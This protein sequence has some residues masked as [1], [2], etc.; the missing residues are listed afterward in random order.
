MIS[1]A[2]IRLV[3]KQFDAIHAIY[4]YQYQ[5]RMVDFYCDRGRVL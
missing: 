2:R 1:E 3:K 4:E 5:F